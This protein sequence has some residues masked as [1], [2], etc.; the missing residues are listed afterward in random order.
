MSFTV[1]LLHESAPSHEFGEDASYKVLD[2]GVLQV[3]EGDKVTLWGP[4]AWGR[5]EHVRTPR[6][7]R[8]VDGVRGL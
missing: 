3:T 1:A 5:V 4:A 2:G 6:V 7:P 8:V